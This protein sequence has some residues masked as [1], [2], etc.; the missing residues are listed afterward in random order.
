MFTLID[1]GLPIKFLATLIVYTCKEL[2]D[3]LQLCKKIYG[4]HT[5]V[6]RTFLDFTLIY[7]WQFNNVELCLSK[8]EFV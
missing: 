6:Y 5:K 7:F 4:E 8:V 1:A 3:V 2:N